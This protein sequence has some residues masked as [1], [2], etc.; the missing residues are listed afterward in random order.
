MAQFLLCDVLAVVLCSAVV[1]VCVEYV[2][3]IGLYH[4]FLVVES[5]ETV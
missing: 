4:V 3:D 2:A 1:V 5:A